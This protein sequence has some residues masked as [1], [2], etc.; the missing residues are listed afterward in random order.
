MKRG[1]VLGMLLALGA[2]AAVKAQPP[3][4]ITTI[5]P[6]NPSCRPA[7]SLRWR[8][9]AKAVAT[10][11]TTRSWPI[12]TP[13]LNEKSDQPSARAGRS[14]SRSTLANPKP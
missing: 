6:V 7:V 11:E 9:A 13:T 5:D 4:A 8:S 12:S 3:A 1:V 10:T 14:I 2:L